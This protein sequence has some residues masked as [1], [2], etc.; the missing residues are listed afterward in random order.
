MLNF[1]RFAPQANWIMMV[2]EPV[3]SCESWV[4]KSYPKNDYSG[5]VSQISTMLFETDNVFYSRHRSVGVRL[6]DLKEQPHKPFL[7]YVNGWVL[8][9]TKAYMK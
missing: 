3:Q 6:E 4:R 2:R 7:H 8:K 5:M 1:S 9:K